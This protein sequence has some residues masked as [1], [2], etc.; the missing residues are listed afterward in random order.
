MI[1]VSAAAEE[2]SV[3]PASVVNVVVSVGLPVLVVSTEV[4]STVEVGSSLVADVSSTL[5]VTFASCSML[6]RSKP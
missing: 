2:E 1:V 4:K 5:T 6:D 3:V